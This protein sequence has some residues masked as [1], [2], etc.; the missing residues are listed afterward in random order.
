[1]STVRPE[2][3]VVHGNIVID[4][5]ST[6]VDQ[7]SLVFVAPVEASKAGPGPQI[8]ESVT[9]RFGRLPKGGA[10]EVLALERKQQQQTDRGLKVIA[11]ESIK[12]QLG[13]GHLAAWKTTPL[14]VA[15][16]RLA[17]AAAHGDAYVLAIATTTEAAFVGAR[18]RLLDIIGSLRRRA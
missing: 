3:S 12:T 11:E 16:V 18:G 10:A 15:L 6:W 1:M 13:P 17:V 14:D 5:P 7:S 4:I 2:V 8:A 9:V